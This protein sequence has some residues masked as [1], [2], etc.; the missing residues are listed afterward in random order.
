MT[1][2][3]RRSR[4]EEALDAERRRLADLIDLEYQERTAELKRA[5][6]AARSELATA[7]TE[8]ARRLGEERREEFAERERSAAAEYSMRLVQVQKRVEDR[9]TAWTHDLERVTGEIEGRSPVSSAAEGAAGAGRA[10]DRPG[11]RVL[12][13]RPTT[14]ASL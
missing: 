2:V 3:R 10:A 9:L 7:L 14:S 8:E 4:E 6:A 1:V 11:S 13:G 5:L 12:L